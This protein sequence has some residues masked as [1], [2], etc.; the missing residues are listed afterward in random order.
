[1]L[2]NMALDTSVLARIAVT[3]FSKTNKYLNE[4]GRYFEILP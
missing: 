3:K 1:M 4:V 2:L